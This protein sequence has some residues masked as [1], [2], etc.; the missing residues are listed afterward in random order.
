MSMS[1][2]I[3]KFLSGHTH[4]DTHTQGTDCYTRTTKVVDKMTKK[5]SYV[6]RDG[7]RHGSD[8]VVSGCIGH[9]P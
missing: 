5:S 8:V 7:Q 3:E 1:E 2:V 9:R 6:G 4:T